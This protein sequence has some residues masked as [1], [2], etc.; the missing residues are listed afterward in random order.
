[1]NNSM[2][3][4]CPVCNGQGNNL[5]GRPCHVCNGH[6]IISTISGLPPVHRKYNTTTSSTLTYSDRDEK[7]MDIIGQ[8]G[9][10][11][12]H[13]DETEY[14]ALHGV[15]YDKNEYCYDCLEISNK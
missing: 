14:C 13:Y 12:L 11:G 1:M 9:N 10:E 15:T 7:R 4:A 6:G 3:Q 5:L 2:W 8:N